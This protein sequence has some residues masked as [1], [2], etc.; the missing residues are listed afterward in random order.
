MKWV[1]VTMDMVDKPRR[2]G[3]KIPEAQKECMSTLTFNPSVAS[4]T[5]ESNHTPVAQTLPRKQQ[6]IIVKWIVINRGGSAIMK[7]A[8][9][10][11]QMVGNIAETQKVCMPEV[12]PVVPV[13][14]VDVGSRSSTA[15][16]PQQQG[17]PEQQ[18]GFNASKADSERLHPPVHRPDSV[19]IDKLA[20]TFIKFSLYIKVYNSRGL[21]FRP[22]SNSGAKTST[23]N[24][25][26]NAL[27]NLHNNSF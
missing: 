25:S 23:I 21:L 4:T 10:P 18:G 5:T 7:P 2:T 6:K 16:I 9:R 3:S 24:S 19:D 1:A 22:A 26:T 11:R 15:T 14:N 20:V 12:S 13:Y 17:I 27:V 8:I